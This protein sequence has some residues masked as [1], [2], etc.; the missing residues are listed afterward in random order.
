MAEVA[1]KYQDNLKSIKKNVE[2]SY[3]YFRENYERF[4]DFRRFVFKSSMTSDE[5]SL[6][7][8]QGKPQLEFNIL[9]SYISR[10]RGEFS[11]QEP[12]ISVR[13]ADGAKNI[14]SK[15]IDFVESHL[16]ATL[17][18][19]NNDGMEYDIYTDLLSGG[20]S[21]AKIYTEFA[22]EMSFNQ[23]ILWRRVFDP[24]LCGFDPL[25]RASHKG[26]GS[27]CFE[28]YPKT[29]QEIEDELGKGVADSFKFNRSE[30][31]FSWSYQNNEEDIILL[32][33]YYEKKKKR[34]KIVQVVTG[35]V[36]TW[37]DYQDLVKKWNDSGHIQQPPGIVGKPR[38]TDIET[39]CRYRFIENKV[40]E[41]TETDYKHLPLVFFDANSVELR[42]D[43][44]GGSVEQLTRPYVY[45][46]RGVQKLK[47]FAGQTLANFLENI[48]Q[49]KL[50]MSEEG[51]VEEYKDALINF[52]KASVIVSRAY[53]DEGNPIPQPQTVPL[54]PAPPEVTNTFTMTDQITQAIL[55]NFDMDIGHMPQDAMSGIA[56]QESLSMSNSAA[57]PIVV[58]FL[59]GLNRLANIYVDLLPKYIKSPRSLPTLGKNNKRTYQT[60][61]SD[62]N[63][64]FNSEDAM[65]LDYNS[66]EL[67]VKVEAGI[68]FELQKS[69][70][71]QVILA[72]TKASPQFAQF[73]NTN[74]LMAILDNINIRGIDQMKQEAEVWTEQQKK[75]QAMMQQM[76]MQQMQQNGGMNPQMAKVQVDQQKLQLESKQDQQENQ[77]KM[78]ELQQS[79]QEID[80][81]RLKI[82]M[83]MTQ[84][85]IDAAVEADKAEAERSRNAIDLAMEHHDMTH[86]HMMDENKHALDLSAH[87]LDIHSA[88]NGMNNQKE[89]EN[90]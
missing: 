86:R 20:F 76:Q 13:A 64:N 17:S 54:I 16:R 72:L 65:H 57:M 68:N 78:I 5:V 83:E 6:L 36:M 39:I 51:I 52:Q 88:L 7:K 84:S 21:V 87:G 77:M 62:K 44:V 22:S 71:L 81:D 4:S 63:S 32:C 19:A 40:V 70:D 48:I 38:M 75:Q 58:G 66:N 82:H 37:D 60:V 73:F 74:G 27:Y 43:G 35:E 11:K 45:H 25:A 29:K 41:Y 69:K 47:N 55:G 8:D 26:D 80:N 49:H 56:I 2:K 12:S 46:A 31:S 1:K 9:E 18:D 24:T 90:G 3:Q 42:K 53:T 23:N 79:Q 10:L 50:I 14:D 61:F 89:K 34:T 15:T 59:R 30:G 85:Q 28:L 67:E 33:D